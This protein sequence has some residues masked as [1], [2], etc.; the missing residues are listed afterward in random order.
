[1]AMAVPNIDSSNPDYASA[2]QHY[3]KLSRLRLIAFAGWL[4]FGV[5]VAGL[6]HLLDLSEHVFPFLLL[7]WFGFIVVALFRAGSFQCPRCHDAFFYTWYF[8]NPLA[9]RCV[10]CNLPKWADESGRNL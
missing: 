10:H 1:M 9:R 4:P 5:A 7:P 6:A 3:R 8:S 2:W